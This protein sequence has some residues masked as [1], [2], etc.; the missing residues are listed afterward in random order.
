MKKLGTFLVCAVMALGLVGCGN[1]DSGST[2]SETQAETQTSDI[3]DAAVSEETTDEITESVSSE[4]NGSDTA[5]TETVETGKTLVVYFSA[6]GNT[7]EA[8]DLIADE[9][10]ADMFEIVPAQEYTSD[11][12][13]YNDDNSRVSKEHSDESLRDVELASTE[14]PNWSSYSTVFIGYP[15]W[16]G[17][18]AW[19]VDSFVKANDF[20]GKTVY[21]FCTSASSGL[22]DSAVSLANVAGTGDWKDGQRFSSGVTQDDV[23]EWI[24]GLDL[25]K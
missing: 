6:T 2:Q 20:T 4:E 10:G 7:K 3:T 24:G 23:T 5:A 1:G 8:A 11:D 12:L 21:P 19:P 25:D 15:I 18:S 16:W 22:G 14:V 13:D 17:V 9:T